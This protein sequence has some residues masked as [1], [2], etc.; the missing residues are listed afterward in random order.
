VL[1]DFEPCDQAP[2]RELVL[3]GMRERWGDAYDPLANPDL[4]NISASYVDRGADVVVAEIGGEIVATG[5]LR[6]EGDGRGRIVR[7]SV[8]QAHRQRGF[9]R[10]LV[11]ELVRRARRRGMLEVVVLTDTPWTSALALYRSC[12]FND[13]G[14]DEND[15][16][17]VLPL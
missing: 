2:V 8:D 13:V 10:Q 11:E 1:R 7:V 4:D 16:H 17:F 3:S 12:G 6:P 14:E 15:T 5:M 9:G